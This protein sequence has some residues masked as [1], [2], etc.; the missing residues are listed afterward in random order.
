[1]TQVDEDEWPEGWGS[2]DEEAGALFSAQ[3]L[4][5]TGPV[6]GLRIESLICVGR[7]GGSDDMVFAVEGWEAPY[8]V[9]HLGWAKPDRRNWLARKFRPWPQLAPALVPIGAIG[10]LA[11]YFD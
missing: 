1:M 8:F 10:D 9:A 7:F 4:S 2:V 5:E 6:E 11:R 3:L